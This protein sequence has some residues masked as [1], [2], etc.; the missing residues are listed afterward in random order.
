[1]IELECTEKRTD[2]QID[3]QMDKQDKTYRAPPVFVGG[4]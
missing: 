4:P 1:M 3:L 2:R